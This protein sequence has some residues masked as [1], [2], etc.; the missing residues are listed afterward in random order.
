MMHRHDVTRASEV[1]EPDRLLRTAMIPNPRTVGADGHDRSFEWP[2]RT[3][4]GKQRRLCRVAANQQRPAFATQH[5]P[6]VAAFNSTRPAPAPMLDLERFDFQ[7][8]FGTAKS[9]L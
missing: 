3:N 6:V 2:A 9:R 1:R 8:A 7:I 4:V 5:V